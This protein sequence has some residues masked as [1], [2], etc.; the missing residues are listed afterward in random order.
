MTITAE[1][2]GRAPRLR[3]DERAVAQARLGKPR[4]ET[5]L[6]M[7]MPPAEALG[8]GRVITAA[9][10]VPDSQAAPPAAEPMVRP[11]P[12]AKPSAV[13][14]RAQI[15]ALSDHVASGSGRS[16]FSATVGGSIKVRRP[17]RPIVPSPDALLDPVLQAV[18]QRPVI[19]MPA[20]PG[21]EVAAPDTGRVAFGGGFGN[22]GLLLILEHDRD[23]HTILWGFSKLNVAT[24]ERVEAGDIIGVMG[25]GGSSELRVEFRRNGRPV[26]ILPWLAASSSKVRG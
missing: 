13:A 21:Q 24:D 4:I 17:S 26:G 23:Y 2:A 20:R 14:K 11:P 25:D 6:P 16:S 5:R 18:D 19:V 9:L 15:A 8:G 1:R 7:A 3:A 12:P 22:Y 10:V